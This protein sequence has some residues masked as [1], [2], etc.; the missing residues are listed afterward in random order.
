MTKDIKQRT[1]TKHLGM[2]FS[3]P[4][5]P[6]LSAFHIILVA[7]G[8]VGNTIVFG[9]IGKSVIKEHSV[10]PHS[11]IIIINLVVSNLMVLFMRNVLFIISDLGLKV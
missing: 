3:R 2:G 8:I 5:P 11:D 4:L 10:G 9:V 6:V 1:T 7:F